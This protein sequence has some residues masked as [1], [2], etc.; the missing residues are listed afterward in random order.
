MEVEADRNHVP[1]IVEAL[2]L[3]VLIFRLNIFQPNISIRAVD[4]DMVIQKKLEASP[5]M[6]TESILRI[7]EIARSFDGGVIP[8]TAA[9]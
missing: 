7:V 9:E 5:R 1:I 6:E 3:N 4:G 2:I 8:A